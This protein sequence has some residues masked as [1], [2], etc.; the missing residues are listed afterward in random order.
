MQQQDRAAV[1]DV[2]TRRIVSGACLDHSRRPMA[3]QHHRFSGSVAVQAR[4][5]HLLGCQ[6]W[7]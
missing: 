1:F 4:N 2:V 7:V 3:Q 5:H 6:L